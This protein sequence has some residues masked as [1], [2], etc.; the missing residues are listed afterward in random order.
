MTKVNVYD[1][2][3]S[4]KEKIDLPESFNTPFRPDIIRK[5]FNVLRSNRRQPYGADPL[6]GCKHSTASVGK[7][8]GMSACSKSYTR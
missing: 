3:G 4:S 5:S 6:A 1:L 8:R 7:G 2:N